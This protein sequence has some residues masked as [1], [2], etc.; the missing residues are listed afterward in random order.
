MKAAAGF[1]KLCRRVEP[2]VSLSVEGYFCG[3]VDGMK[4]CLRERVRGGE[5]LP[6]L[7]VFA[8]YAEDHSDKIFLSFEE[9]L[10]LT[11]ELISWLEKDGYAD[12]PFV[13][14][15]G[16]ISFQIDRTANVFTVDSWKV[17]IRGRSYWRCWFPLANED[18]PKVIRFFRAFILRYC[19]TKY[20]AGSMEELRGYRPKSELKPIDWEPR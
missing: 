13:H 14:D 10:S 5:K 11:R 16:E 20:D 12:G 19:E 1:N 3:T 8:Y 7:K 18:L 9:L 4:L 2:C 17:G 6:Y 15:G